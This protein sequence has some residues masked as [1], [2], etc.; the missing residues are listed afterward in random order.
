LYAFALVCLGLSSAVSALSFG[1]LTV[2]SNLGE[3]LKAEVEVRDLSPSDEGSLRLRLA[4]PQ[5]YRLSGLEFDALVADVRAVVVRRPDGRHVIQLTTEKVVNN[6]FVDVILEARWPAGQ[7][8]LGY[9]LLVSPKVVESSVAA[10]SSAPI[11]PAVVTPEPGATAP[12][13]AAAGTT[14]LVSSGET[15]L[16]VARQYKPE[17]VSLDQMLVA[18]YRTNPQAFIG[19]NMNRLKA[20]AVL[21]VPSAG[22]VQEVSQ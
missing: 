1:R 10:S 13:P 4:S 20:G 15:L 11:T 19:A 22:P 8:M 18:L 21:T 3:P 2:Q 9:T 7:R 12:G 14:H 16:G 6:V 5:A 17:G